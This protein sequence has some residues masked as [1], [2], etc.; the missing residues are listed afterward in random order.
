MKNLF[1]SILAL[2]FA[3][4]FHT[5]CAMANGKILV[6]YFS[7]TGENYGVGTI[8]KGNTHIIAEIIAGQTGADLYEIRP[9][10]PYPDGY[11]QTVAIAR[12]ERNENARPAI[13]A[14]LP[15]LTQYDTVFIGYPNWWS[16]MPMILYTF[17]ENADLAGKTII[18]FCTHAGSGLS[19]TPQTIARLCPSSAVLEGLAIP[20]TTAQNDQNEARAAVTRWLKNLAITK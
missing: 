4:S 2:A 11:D 1:I 7:R 9:A 20:G 19:S 8:T 18:P 5:T 17:L 10:V 15:D 3:F 6:A 14:P 16:D 13:A 12:R